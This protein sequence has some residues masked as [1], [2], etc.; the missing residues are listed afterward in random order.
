MFPP[1]AI[2]K[3]QRWKADTMA[4]VTE[5]LGVERVDSWQ[6]KVLRDFDDPAKQRIAMQACV[7]PGKSAVLAW[8]AWKFLACFGE[9]GH[10]PNAAA[11]SVTADNLRDNL[12]KEL[13]VWRNR[14][15]FLQ[16]A[17]EWTK[18]R[19]F[20]RDHPETWFLAARTWSKTASPEE[21][22]KTLSGLHSKYILY[23][24]DE[25]G[26]IHPAILRSGEQGLSN[27]VW[28][29]IMQAGNPT[30]HSGMLKLAAGLQRHL[31]ALHRVTGDPDSPDRSPR[32]GLD[33]ARQQITEYGRENPWV[34]AHILGEFPPASINVLLGTDE[35]ESAMG[36]QI[37]EEDYAFVQK[38]LGVDVAREG[39]D[40][41]VLAPRQGLAAHEM[42]VMRNARGPEVA[43]RIALAH[44]R[45]GH[46]VDMIDDT[47]GFG[48]AVIDALTQS[49]LNPL[50]INFSGKADDPRYYN[51][52][53]EMWFRMAEWVKRGG[54]LPK[55]AELGREL[56]APTYTFMRGKFLLEEKKQI[57]RRLG[58]SPDKADALALTFAMVDMPA[59]PAGKSRRGK[60]EYEYDP[61]AERA[62]SG[63]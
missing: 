14:S 30:D 47:G 22:G 34:M 28:G 41:T 26:S 49:G 62:G 31:W 2:A 12:W 38:R 42:A 23:L 43:A 50:P 58:F 1:A 40:R 33:W 59:K 61:L 44:E 16:A 39:D 8:C 60:A 4:F 48:G 46:E 36:R 6:E 11:V 37:R 55:D 54:A 10:H 32:I 3:G 45:W 5:E 35:V 25:S 27:C 21:Q 63:G 7:G 56:T 53:S 15:Q 13:A 57:K 20:A 52:R 51:K 18:E 24:I 17:F 9:S 29:K 19:I